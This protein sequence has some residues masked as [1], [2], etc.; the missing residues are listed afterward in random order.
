MSGGGGS[1]GKRKV[2]PAALLDRRSDLSG[3]GTEAD[4]KEGGSWGK[5]AFPYGRELKAS[6]AHSPHRFTSS[7]SNPS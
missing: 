5:H 2:P 1:G 6:D 7:L 3:A 4:S